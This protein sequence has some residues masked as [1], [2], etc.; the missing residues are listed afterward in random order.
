MAS[1][2]GNNPFRPTRPLGRD[3]LRVALAT[4]AL[5]LVPLVAMQFTDEV[6]WGAL[7]FIVAAALLGGTGSA[8]VLLA[9]R[10]SGPRQRMMAGAVLLMAL[11]LVWAELAVGIFH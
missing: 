6:N 5:L 10:L 4:A 11:L 3:I 7:D 9:R 1:M 8:Y 2:T